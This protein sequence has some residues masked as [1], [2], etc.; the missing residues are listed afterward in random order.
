MAQI[1]GWLGQSD[2]PLEGKPEAEALLRRMLGMAELPHLPPAIFEPERLRASRLGD[3]VLRAL[4]A[5]FGGEGFTADPTV[6]AMTSLGQSYPDQLARRAGTVDDPVDAVVRPDNEEDALALLELA[7][8]RGFCVMAA[9]GGTNVTGGFA[10]GDRRP[11]VAADMRRMKR[12]LRVN[13]TDLVAEAEAGISLPDLEAELGVRGFTLG[14]FPQS[15][16]GATLGGSLSAHGSGQRSNGY[17]RIAEM[18]LGA[19]LATP[20]GRWTTEMQ[21]HAASGPWLGGLIAGSEGLFGLITSVRFR[22]HRKPQRIDDRGWLLPSFDVATEAART[23]VQSGAGLSMIRISD[24][25]ETEFLG[26]FRL[27]MKGLIDPPLIERLLLGIK[28][29]AA[30]PAL[31]IAGFEGEGGRHAEAVIEAE[32]V[33]KRAGGVSLG[34]RPGTSW[35]KG[36]Y[37]LPYLRESLMRRGVGVD[38]FETV[39]AWTKLGVVHHAML[40]ALHDVI[41][42]TLKPGKGNGKVLCHLSHS[43]PEG[44]CLYFTA[45]FPQAQDRLA[46]WQAIKSAVMETLKRQGAAAS[47][48]H[49]VGA[50]HAELVRAEKGPIGVEALRALKMALDPD[51]IMVSGMGRLLG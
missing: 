42:G 14:H 46:Q 39:V 20:Q 8:E 41:G 32:R 35:R 3:D 36:R 11:R 10:T 31:V 29:A 26:Q 21:R 38:T 16:H 13:E 22:I 47:H 27:A 43:Y 51:G 23:L 2:D 44:A 24:E 40:A 49:G 12:L 18:M 25:S 4:A 9:G 48:H 45:L 1:W 5:R 37:E 30:N 17:G 28:R 50:D 7:K 19:T 34:S 15:F 6:R 33:F